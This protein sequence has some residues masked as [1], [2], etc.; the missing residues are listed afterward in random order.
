MPANMTHAQFRPTILRHSR[1]NQGPPRRAARATVRMNGA[2]GAPKGPSPCWLASSHLMAPMRQAVIPVQRFTAYT[3]R[4]RP[5]R[6]TASPRRT[7][8]RLHGSWTEWVLA[9]AIALSGCVGSEPARTP[10]ATVTAFAQAVSHGDHETAYG[11]LDP[12]YRRRVSLAAFRRTLEENEAEALALADALTRP[13]TANRQ[14]TRLHYRRVEG[15]VHVI[16]EGG[17]TRLDGRVVD[18]YPQSGPRAALQTFVRAFERGRFDVILRLIPDAYK[19]GASA[20]SIQETWSGECRTDMERVVS[21]LQRALQAPI[22][23]A[24]DHATLAYADH[25]RV[26]FVREGG[27]WKIETLE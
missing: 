18:F 11:L 7:P 21:S 2:I 20:T 24:G 14:E 15:T 8:K 5:S 23:R 19:E 25:R 12:A 17:H 27:L 13:P 10:V 4:P 1:F 26:Q 16:T 9:G 22:E 6:D 3:Y